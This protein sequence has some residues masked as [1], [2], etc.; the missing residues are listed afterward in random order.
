[1]GRFILQVQIHRPEA[2]DDDR[3]DE[4]MLSSGLDRVMMR[5]GWTLGRQLIA[6]YESGTAGQDPNRVLE[7]AKRAVSSLGRQYT[8]IHGMKEILEDYG[9]R[10]SQ[11]R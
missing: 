7:A 9:L 1:M 2:G 4:A 3:L 8:I 5:K 10:A 6:E 11:R